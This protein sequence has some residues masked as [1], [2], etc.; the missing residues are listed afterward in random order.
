MNESEKLSIGRLT[1]IWALAESGLGGYMHAMKIPFTGI[2]VGGAAVLVLSLIAYSSKS[3]FKDI[4]KALAIVLCIKFVVSPQ[5]PFPAYLAVAF[6]GLIA[7]LIFSLP[8]P[9]AL[10][11][12]TFMLL[13]M[14]ESALQKFIL[15]T[16]FY[17]QQI[18]ESLDKMAMMA[19][20]ELGL[21]SI[22]SD[23]TAKV[24]LIY[25]GIYSIW[26]LLLSYWGYVL[27]F[28]IENQ[29][30]KITKEASTLRIIESQK[31]RSGSKKARKPWIGILIV[32]VFLIGSFFLSYSKEQALEK[33]I[34]SVS[35]TLLVLFLYLFALP[36]LLRWLMNKW[37][38]KLMKSSSFHQTME[39]LPYLRSLLPKA[40]TLSAT[41]KFRFQ[42]P[43][44]FI[45]NLLVLSLYTHESDHSL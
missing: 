39:E 42:R 23:F 35:R 25:L 44:A 32:L 30:H 40:W 8:F 24:I 15:T 14:W 19:G 31:I 2:F 37:G 7:A 11:I 28:K 43:L 5:S 4:M 27:P 45:L 12:F 3:P 1:A 21:E 22:S 34:L 18:W 6:Q 13:S 33:A 41:A 9:R 26:A 17:G 38:S 36:P 29:K 16:L 20:K 10:S